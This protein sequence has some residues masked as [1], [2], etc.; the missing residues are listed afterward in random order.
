MQVTITGWG[1]NSTPTPVTGAGYGVQ[2]TGRTVTIGTPTAADYHPDDPNPAMLD[3]AVRQTV[4]EDR[5]RRAPYSNGCFGDSGGPIILSQYGQDY[6]AGSATG[7][8]F[9]VRTTTS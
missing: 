5:R 6:V 1:S 3:P 7:P 9:P 2:R 4:H 8:V